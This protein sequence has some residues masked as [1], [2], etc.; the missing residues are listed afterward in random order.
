M[1]SGKGYTKLSR[2]MVR[3][4]RSTIVDAHP[5]FRSQNPALILCPSDT[6]PLTPT[7]CGG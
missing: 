3:R 7:H 6:V 2:I 1:K 4:V 5:E